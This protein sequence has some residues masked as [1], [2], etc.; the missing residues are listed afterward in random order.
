MREVI[1]IH[2]GQAGVQ[3]GQSAWEL[4]CLEHDIDA[5]G[6]KEVKADAGEAP[7]GESGND[8]NSSFDTFFQETEAGKLV[9]RCV[10]FDLEP[11]VVD[12]VMH[13]KYKEL[14]HPQQMMTGKEDAANNYAR[15][16]YT[17][18]NDMVDDAHDV[19]RR[20]AESCTGIQGF[21]FYHSVGGG[22]GSGFCDNLQSHL[23]AEYSKKT[24]MNFAIWPSPKI[25]NAVVEPYNASLCTDS[26]LENSEVT[27]LFDN[28]AIYDIC[29]RSLNITKPAYV[30]LNRIISQV[31]SSLT[32]SLRFDG[33]LNVDLAEFQT[34]LVPY[35]RIHFMLSSLAPIIPASKSQH[36]TISVGEIVNQCFKPQNLMAKCDPST[37][38][39]MAVC[40]MLRGDISPKDVHQAIT[41]IK[42]SSRVRFVDWCPTGFKTGMCYQSPRHPPEND[43]VPVTR[44]LCM[45]SN[46][47][48]IA[49]VIGRITHKFDLMFSRRAFVHW[50]V[51]E[52]MEE[53]EFAEAR[54]NLAAL[55][56]DYEQVLG[57]DPLD[58]AMDE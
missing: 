3:L 41:N 5:S 23:C 51:G 14:F 10:M 37:S 8:Y 7:A 48:A 50:Y 9:P 22:T 4:F 46:S 19:I 58:E 1:S 43:M 12:E 38:K 29:N 36:E 24:K 15:G 34:N 44:S 30:N 55:E 53:G 56:K 40:L 13:S 57:E 20:L 42:A 47:A 6:R 31:V 25:A 32:A 52:G 26:L 18:G 39:Y 28:E 16:K 21:A 45:I 49:N 11:S 54:E 27:T 35:P 17:A 33:M 2:C